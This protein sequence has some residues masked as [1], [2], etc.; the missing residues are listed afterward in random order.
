[1]QDSKDWVQVV[2][3]LKRRIEP[4]G[5]WFQWLDATGF[6]WNAYELAIPNLPADLEGFRILHLSDLHCRASWKPTYD[7]LIAGV[8]AN[9]PDLILFTGDFVEDKFNPAPGLAVACKLLS[10]LKSRRGMVGIRGNHDVYIGPADLTGTPIR[11]IEGELAIV[12]QIEIVA[13]PG[14]FRHS[15][16]DSFAATIPPKS[17]GRPRIIL[18]HVPDHIRPLHSLSADILLAGHTHGGQVCLPGGI[19][20]IRHD[21]LPRKYCCG[22]H[23]MDETWL[24]VSRGF[25]FSSTPIRLFCPAEV[26]ELRLT[27]ANS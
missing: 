11:L 12:E 25:G 17:P 15:M 14:P 7:R 13:V 21:S 4:A 16:T 8:A 10:Q 27:R 26:A 5:P 6:E 1:M 2:P 3:G 20:I 22:V 18:S 19:P 24:V 9:P 23:R